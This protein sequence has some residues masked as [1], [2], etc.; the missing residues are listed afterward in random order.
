MPTI[1]CILIFIAFVD[2]I[3]ICELIRNF[4]AI[5]TFNIEKKTPVI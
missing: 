5:T 1:C 2:C 4:I 3:Q